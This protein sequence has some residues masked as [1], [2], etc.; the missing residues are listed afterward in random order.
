DRYATAQ[1][2]ADDLWRFLDDKPVRARR[3][4]LRQVTAKWAR[5]HRAAV[6]AAAAGALVALAG[7]AAGTF[8]RVRQLGAAAQ[9]GPAAAGR[10]RKQAG[11]AIR[12]RDAAW[13][14]V[15]DMYTQVAQKWLAGEPGMSDVQLEFL[16]KALH[17]YEALAQE[18][19]EGPELLLERAKVS[20]RV[21]AILAK[22]G[23]R[24]EA[25]AAYR[26]AV[27]LLE[28]ADVPDKVGP[29]AGSYYELGYFLTESRDRNA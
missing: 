25:E 19:S 9:G 21:G 8:W 18:E 5:R 23:R 7:A 29:L 15:D 14:A 6:W 26:H 1:E 24:P 22:L 11:R 12:Q 17:Y 10:E 16:E 4:S 13:R 27:S 3:P 2:L 28:G 20:R